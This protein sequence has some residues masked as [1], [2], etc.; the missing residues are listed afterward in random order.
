MGSLVPYRAAAVELR[1]FYV[2]L[3][4]SFCDTISHVLPKAC[5]L[6]LSP[7]N[8]TSETNLSLC[9][10]L[11]GHSLKQKLLSSNLSLELINQACE[12]EMY[13]F[14]DQQGPLAVLLETVSIFQISSLIGSYRNSMNFKASEINPCI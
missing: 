12:E 11:L 2:K 1:G 13:Q 6:S 4:E 5:G 14:P 7:C 9:A 10:S 3:W 8:A